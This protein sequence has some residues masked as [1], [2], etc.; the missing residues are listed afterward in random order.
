MANLTSLG[1]SSIE[2]NQARAS[3]TTHKR[4][5][6]NKCRIRLED[7]LELYQAWCGGGRQWRCYTYAAALGKKDFM[8]MNLE[9]TAA[10]DG[11]V[12][13]EEGVLGFQAAF[14]SS[15]RR[16]QEVAA[17]RSD[18]GNS[19][20]YAWWKNVIKVYASVNGSL[21]FGCLREL[22]LIFEQGRRLLKT[23]TVRLDGVSMGVCC[24]RF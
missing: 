20:Q 17:V 1:Y 21:Y 3:N 14:W 18:C 13:C 9:A 8:E 5:R 12:T 10:S 16:E 23:P 22:W 19:S 4:E 2:L 11:Q 7:C 15:Y 6:D 24:R